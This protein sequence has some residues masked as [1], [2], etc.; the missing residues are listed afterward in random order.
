MR[1]CGLRILVELNRTP[2]VRYP[3]DGIEKMQFPQ[4]EA[5][6]DRIAPQQRLYRESRPVPAPDRPHQNTPL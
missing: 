4:I 3:Q 2:G 5:V 6:K 1:S